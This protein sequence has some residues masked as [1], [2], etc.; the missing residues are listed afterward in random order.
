MSFFRYGF[1]IGDDLG[2]TQVSIDQHCPDEWTIESHVEN[3][4]ATRCK[5]TYLNNSWYLTNL[6][7]D[8]QTTDLVTVVEMTE[9]HMEGFI[10]LNQDDEKVAMFDGHKC[11]F[12]IY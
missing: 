2:N 7:S 10:F 12:V 6:R 11:L 1:Y 4:L 5:L 9:K 3:L 8:I